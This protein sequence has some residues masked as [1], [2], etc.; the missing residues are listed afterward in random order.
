MQKSGEIEASNLE[1][2]YCE[3]YN[4]KIYDL[5]NPPPKPV[6]QKKPLF[7]T[8]NISSTPPKFKPH[9]QVRESAS[10]GVFVS[11]LTNKT[12]TTLADAELCLK[13][14]NEQRATA[15]TGMN[16]QS[17]RSHSIFQITL[18][19]KERVSKE[20]EIFIFNFNEVDF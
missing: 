4:E 2:S 6:K 12:V 18:K 19:I 13:N 1:V 5:L 15:A 17:S 3:V 14:G 16:D 11:G 7:S 10:K 8:S 20:T 9:L